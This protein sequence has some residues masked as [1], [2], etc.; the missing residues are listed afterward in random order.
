MTVRAGI[1][2]IP[3]GVWVLGIVSMCMDLSSEL[4]H[5]LYMATAMGA[6]ML[7]IGVVEGIAEAT[8]LIVKLFSGALS[9][10]SRKRKPL[11]LLGYGL[12]A[13]SKFVFPLAPSSATGPPTPGAYR[14]PCVSVPLTFLP[15]LLPRPS[16]T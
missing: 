14:K 13:V 7:V 12:A 8:A 9:D 10:W 6:S 5:A 16:R 3:R 2:G 4:V 1:T 15:V 11:V